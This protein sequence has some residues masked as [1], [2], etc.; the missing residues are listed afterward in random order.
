MRTET[1]AT[2]EGTSPHRLQRKTARAD[3]IETD[4][5]SARA[6]GETPKRDSPDG[7]HPPDKRVAAGKC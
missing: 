2:S 5:D 1:F 3:A 6:G 7:W 4:C